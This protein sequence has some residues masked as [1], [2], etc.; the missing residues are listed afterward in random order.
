MNGGGMG[1]GQRPPS[2]PRGNGNFSGPEQNAFEQQKYEQQAR[3]SSNAPS[4]PRGNQGQ[5]P[6]SWEGMYDDVPQPEGGSGSRGGSVARHNTL[7]PGKGGPPS[8][9][10]NAPANAPTGPKNPGKPGGGGFRGG[11]GHGRY[12]PYGR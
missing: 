11:R 4:G 6:Q 12:H 1:G 2:G 8:Q 5:G 10:S 3:R 9:P 7:K